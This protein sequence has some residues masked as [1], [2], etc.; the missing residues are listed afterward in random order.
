MME[1]E[2][3]AKLLGKEHRYA[4]LRKLF[5]TG[6][7]YVTQLA[8]ELDI[9]RR[10]LGRYLEEL[11]KAD[12][13]KFTEEQRSEGGKPYRYYR[14]TDS[15]EK[16][17]STYMNITTEVHERKPERWQIDKIVQ[18]L[19]D[20]SLSV[21][22]RETAVNRFFSFCQDNPTYMTENEEVQGILEDTV[23]K[24]TQLE[25]KLGARLRASVSTSFPRLLADDD[26][27]RW[28]LEKLYP[29]LVKCL[30]D[31]TKDDNIRRWALRLIGDVCRIRSNRQIQKEAREKIFEVYF[32]SETNSDS[33]L[34]E[35]AK[36][37]LVE[38]TSEDLF[39][40]IQQKT[41]SEDKLERIKAE[42]LIDEMI[43]SFSLRRQVSTQTYT[44]DL[45]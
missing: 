12:L 34:G 28:A 41:E 1:E 32:S 15:G 45:F 2:D 7:R 31:K 29:A 9:E 25:E 19:K 13:V 43:K 8:S 33:R 26:R 42:I 3:V 38:L 14:L 4:I 18:L 16:I 17:V 20:E 39:E 23:E 36:R 37:E 27:R 11:R 10:N 21:N 44:T 24:P 22:L 5:P 6:K 35:E 40:D 30:K